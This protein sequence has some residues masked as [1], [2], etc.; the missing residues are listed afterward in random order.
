MLTISK[1]GGGGNLRNKP[2]KRNGF[3]LIELLAVIVILA[4]IALIVVP[5]VIKILNKARLSSAEDSTY[6]IIKSVD[7]YVANFMLKND[8]SFP[9]EEIKFKCNSDG[10]KLD[11]SSLDTNLIGYN[12]EGLGELEFKGSKPSD[13]EVV[14]SNNGQTIKVNNLKINGFTCNY[15]NNDGKVSC[16]NGNKSDD[17]LEAKDKLENRTYKSGEAITNFAGYNWHVIG[18]T[19]ENVT[20]LMD[21]NQIEDMAHCT[22]DLDAST[23]CGV[24]SL[25]Q[26]YVYSWD[27]SLINKYLKETLYPELK[28]KISNEIEPISVCI[29][30]SRGDGVVTYGGYLKPEIEKISGS[31][32]GNGYETDYVRLITY[33]EYWNLSP[34]YSGTDASYPNVSGITRLSKNSDYAEWLYCNSNKCGGTGYAGYWWT[35]STYSSDYAYLIKL[36]RNV[37]SDGSLH[38][39]NGEYMFGV[40]PVITIKKQ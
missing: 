22:D 5:Q 10:C 36:A 39:F 23:D 7:T 8:G 26:Y 13:G 32:C 1:N 31:S 4:I 29:D 9:N 6:G 20:L 14:V 2:S 35:M 17:N 24:D 27:K 12:L 11:T 25:G 19:S 33:S 30:S 16:E 37:Y 34:Y 28:N 15:P 40:R 3:T 18:E 38:K 21:A